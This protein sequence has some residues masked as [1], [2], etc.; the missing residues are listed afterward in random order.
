MDRSTNSRTYADYNTLQAATE[1][2]VSMY[3]A[4]L[5]ATNKQAAQ[6]TYDVT[7]LHRFLDSLGDISCLT[8]VACWGA[9]WVAVGG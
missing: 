5:K 9:D 7:D 2:I 6:I 4:H 1:G 8:C 3:E